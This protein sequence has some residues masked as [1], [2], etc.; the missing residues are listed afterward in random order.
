MTATTESAELG[1]A[2]LRSLAFG[3]KSPAG[4][5][6]ARSLTRRSDVPGMATGSLPA[7]L[8]PDH[9]AVDDLAD[10]GAAGRRH[11]AETA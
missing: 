11:H 6:I 9:D 1:P 2:F 8:G 7:G 5:D 10:L 4:A 3:M